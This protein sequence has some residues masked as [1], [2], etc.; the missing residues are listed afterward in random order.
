MAKETI[1]SQVALTLIHPILDLNNVHL[2]CQQDGTLVTTDQIFKWTGPRLQFQAAI[3]ALYKQ[4]MLMSPSSG[5]M[6]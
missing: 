3:I 1:Q 4:V 6:L 2:K 5:W